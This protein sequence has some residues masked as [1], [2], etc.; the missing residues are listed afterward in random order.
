MILKWA[1][2]AMFIIFGL[3]PGGPAGASD[4]DFSRA[5]NTA[6]CI[7][8]KVD[9]MR[10]EQGVQIYDVSCAGNPPRSVGVFC[11]KHT[12]SVS[13]GGEGENSSNLR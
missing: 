13:S 12:C 3:V 1:V 10:K 8:T 6:G 5:L 7:P 11:T 4:A 9:P 2:A